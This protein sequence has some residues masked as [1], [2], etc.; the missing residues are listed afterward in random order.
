MRAPGPWWGVLSKSHVGAAIVGHAVLATCGH[1]MLRVIKIT[2]GL[3][4][5]SLPIWPLGSPL[6]PALAQWP[7]VRPSPPRLV[8]QYDAAPRSHVALRLQ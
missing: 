1:I 3:W 6:D 2:G 7:C 8:A 5:D 4:Q